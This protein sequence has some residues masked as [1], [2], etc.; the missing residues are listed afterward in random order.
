MI[1]VD[2]SAIVDL[3]I[4]APRGRSVARHLRDAGEAWAPELLQV[5]VASALWRL[6]RGG[7]LTD[8]EASQAVSDALAVPVES[9]PHVLL[10]T[11]AWDLRQDLRI[12]DAFYVALA[13]HLAAPLLTT[14]RRL[15]RAAR[16]ISVIAVT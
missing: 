14:D 7:V 10:G 15:A 11:R 6:N 8:D 9:V 3:V 2:A 1:V 16:G 5:E 13:E 12:S 4:D